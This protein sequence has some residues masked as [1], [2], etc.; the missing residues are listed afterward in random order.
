MTE[1]LDNAELKA[2]LA[3]LEAESVET[4]G[5][6]VLRELRIEGL[7]QDNARLRG[8]IAELQNRA[9]R[10]EASVVELY[11]ESRLFLEACELYLRQYD[12]VHHGEDKGE[13]PMVIRAAVAKVKGT[14]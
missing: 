14:E 4:S 6:L 13:T 8:R 7:K 1:E 9:E 2:L 10:A 11:E 12:S 3:K 5:Q